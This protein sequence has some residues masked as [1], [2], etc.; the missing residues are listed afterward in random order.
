VVSVTA[1]V[2]GSAV[3]EQPSQSA[4]DATPATELPSGEATVS[5]VPDYARD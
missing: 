5:E 4:D 1:E 3:G 2:T